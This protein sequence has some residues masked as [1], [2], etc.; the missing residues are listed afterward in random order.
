MIPP[1]QYTST[2]NIVHYWEFA[3]QSAP[4]YTLL[5]NTQLR[6]M[7]KIWKQDLSLNQLNAINQG[8]MAEFLGICFTEIGDNYLVATMPANERTLQPA[9]I[10]HGGANVALAESVAS[11]AANLTIDRSLYRAVGQ[12][13]NANH[14]RPVSTGLVTATAKPLHLGVTSQVW[15]IEIV[16]ADGK[17]T[18]ISRMTAAIIKA[19]KV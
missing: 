4:L 6:I 11:L 18:C 5:E 8:T 7:M 19:R 17:L 13:I 12:E 3:N 2:L 9:G 16:N 14:I 15:H 10:V 1:H